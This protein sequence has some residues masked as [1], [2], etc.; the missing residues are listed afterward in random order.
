MMWAD[1]WENSDWPEVRAREEGGGGED[2]VCGELVWQVG[3]AELERN[4]ARRD[5]GVGDGDGEVV[6]EDVEAT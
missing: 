6:S 2:E 5:G 3:V 1:E 4:D